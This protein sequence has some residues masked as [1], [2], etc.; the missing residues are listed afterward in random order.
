MSV[1]AHNLYDFVHQALENRYWLMYFY[2]WG[3]RDISNIID[4]QSSMEQINSNRGI[5]FEKQ[6]IRKW[7]P[8]DSVTITGV[9]AWQP[10]I[11]C[12]DQEPL[13]YDLYTDD[14]ITSTVNLNK[15]NNIYI[16]DNNLRNAH[17]TSWH[18]KWILLH[19]ELNSLEVKKYEAT[20]KFATAYWWSHGLISRD[21]YRYAEYD[22]AL[23][24]QNISK[25]KFLV[26]CRGLDGSRQYRLTFLEMLN[27][28]NL[29][30]YC[31]LTNH[32]RAI[33]STASAEYDSN[34]FT[35][36]DI[37]VVLET[38][39][40]SS[41]IHLTEKTLRPIACGHPFILAA[42][43]GSLE[44]LKTYGFQSFSP[45]ID[46]SYDLISDPNERLLKISKEMER[47]A[48]LDA[49]QYQTL[50]C[51]CQSIAQYNKQLFFSN[52]FLNQ[53]TNEMITNVSIASEQIAIDVQT[54][55]KFHNHVN[56]LSAATQRSVVD[57][58]LN[59]FLQYVTQH[60]SIEGYVIPDQLPRPSWAQDR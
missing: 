1:P 55:L 23:S 2:P 36:S 31:N 41:R 4:Y 18:K 11:L 45:W 38:I 60:G 13:N 53:V 20:E 15:Q 6:S 10:T 42:G 14:V 9:K 28:F 35:S 7:W 40:E 19:S 34:D 56:K 33:P 47:I 49:A 57:L 26:Y 43:P 39:F 48:S 50:I 58:Y 12:Y 21:W 27:R 3:S 16:P 30:K 59:S 37:S 5:P 17:P 8:F 29:L 46:E 24:T 25:D 54:R 44:Y 52:K 32:Q 51:E 22:R